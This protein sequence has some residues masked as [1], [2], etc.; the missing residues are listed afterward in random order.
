MKT[1]NSPINLYQNGVQT[2]RVPSD[3]TNF[4]FLSDNGAKIYFD[5]EIGS[6]DNTL[7]AVLLVQTNSSCNTTGYD[8]LASTSYINHRNEVIVIHIYLSSDSS[9]PVTRKPLINLSSTT[10]SKKVYEVDKNDVRDGTLVFFYKGSGVEPTVRHCVF[11]GQFTS[12]NG[13]T[14]LSCIQLNDN[15]TQKSFNVADIIWP[16]I[17]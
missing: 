3:A 17:V 10:A 8:F 5:T 7:K 13:N 11:M 12:S 16:V 1:L 14:L 15:N 2:I 6:S 9:E 4:R